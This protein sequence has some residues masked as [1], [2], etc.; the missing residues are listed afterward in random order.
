MSERGFF[1]TLEGP[2]GSGKST[3]AKRLAAAL[4][5]QGCR[6][7]EVR[8]PGTTTLGTRLRAVLLHERRPLSAMTEALLFIAGRAQLVKER[9]RPALA[10]GGVVVCDRFHDST[11][12]YQ[13]DAGGVEVAWLNRLGRHAIGGLMP[14]LTIVLDVPPRVG[15]ARVRG[16]KD[17][18]ERKTLAFHRRVRA[19]YRRI[20]RAEPRRVIIVDATQSPLVV[21]RQIMET[22]WR[23]LRKHQESNTAHHHSCIPKHQSARR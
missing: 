17:R 18:M 14:H 4:R 21:H 23:H 11:M 9:I 13:G 8:D 7:V 15:L 1:I 3:Q 16:A 6:V 19:G 10:R 20:A 2:E 22:A 12:A 5:R